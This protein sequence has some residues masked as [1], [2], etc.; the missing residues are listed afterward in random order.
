[1]V[2]CAASVVG[3]A[4]VSGV[5]AGVSGVVA[6][7]ASAVSEAGVVAAERTAATSPLALASSVQGEGE[8]QGD[9]ENKCVSML[10]EKY[11]CH[12]TSCAL[13][14]CVSVSALFSAASRDS[15]PACAGCYREPLLVHGGGEV[16]LSPFVLFSHMSFSSP[17]PS[18]FVTGLHCKFPS[19]FVG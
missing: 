13:C 4:G 2:V 5:A 11:A 16:L 12:H 9:S 1:M 15:L 7:S 3:V 19:S 14:F 18:S 17:F 6:G 8:L 10:S